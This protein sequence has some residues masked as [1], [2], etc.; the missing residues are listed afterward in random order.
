MR[1]GV[2]LYPP[3]GSAEP[4]DLVR[5]AEGAERLGFHSVWLGDHVAWP[6][7]FDARDH[8]RDV[9]GKPP[10]PAAVESNV[11][12]PIT[13]LAFL[14]GRVDRVRLGVG[15]LV[16][17]YRHPVLSAKMLAMLDVLSGGRLIV[18]IGAG[19]LREEF[20]LLGSTSYEH[21]GTVTDEYIEVFRQ[22]WVQDEPSFEGVYARVSDLRLNPKPVQ[23]PHP[24]IWVGGNGEAGL[25][26]AARFGD[27]WMPLHQRPGEMSVKVARLI[28][29]LEARGRDPGTVE[30]AVGCRFHLDWNAGGDT[31]G[32]SMVGTAAELLERIG[33]Y[34][35][36]GVRQ[37]NL[38][39][40]GY[41]S[42]DEL[43]DAWDR[44]MREVVASV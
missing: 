11:L 35:Q 5:L 31:V 6:G 4:D 12:E 8:H 18:G 15:V 21:R 2:Y 25:V 29:L 27:A 19:W 22:L 36:A 10:P 23:K 41:S 24:P 34:Q 3:R 33:Q 9:G 14:A 42:V 16:A 20:Q 37:L 1:Y 30:V 13:T 38:I 7:R 28:E 43:L 26:R 44:F 40:E 17:P 32:S 39:S